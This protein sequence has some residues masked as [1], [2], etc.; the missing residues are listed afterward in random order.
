VFLCLRGQRRD[1]SEVRVYHGFDRQP[2]STFRS[3]IIQQFKVY[4]FAVR[5][6]HQ[7]HLLSCFLTDTFF[8]GALEPHS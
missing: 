2:R 4:Y 8:G 1:L 7:H 5:I 6:F 3:L